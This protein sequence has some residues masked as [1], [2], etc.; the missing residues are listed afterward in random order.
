MLFDRK[1][2][3][4]SSLAC[5][6]RLIAIRS[7]TFPGTRDLHEKVHVVI[8]LPRHFLAYLQKDL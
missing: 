1:L 3:I 6:N 4:W 2:R 8:R 7:R 5:I